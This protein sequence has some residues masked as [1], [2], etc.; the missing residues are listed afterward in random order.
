MNGS[1]EWVSKAAES[2]W[3]EQN[4]FCLHK[5]SGYS[6]VHIRYTY[7]RILVFRSRYRG[8]K[9]SSLMQTDLVQCVPLKSLPAVG[10][11]G[12]ES[13]MWC[14]GRWLVL[15]SA[16]SPGRFFSP[17]DAGWV[18]YLQ[19]AGLGSNASNQVGSWLSYPLPPGRED[20]LQAI[21][22]LPGPSFLHL[23]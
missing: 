8:G 6:C 21:Y 14:H 9:N 20:S 15:L 3:D 22:N 12:L 7:K 16:E 1:H 10:T 13:P 19:E 4:P 17:G 2:N 18:L 23:P 5:C 11:R